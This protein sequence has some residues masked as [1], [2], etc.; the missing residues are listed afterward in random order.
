MKA[1][2]KILFL[3]SFAVIANALDTTEPFEIGFSN[4]EMYFITGGL[5]STGEKTFI[6]Y[7]YVTG[8]GITDR[9]ST[10]CAV[11]ATANENL[12]PLTH[13]VSTGVFY[14]AIT[15]SRVDIDF[16]A[17]FSTAGEYTLGTEIN[18]DLA[19]TG[20]QLMVE[21]AF[22]NATDDHTSIA[23]T[24]I[25][26][27]LIYRSLLEDIQLLAAFDIET[28]TDER[29]IDI[30]STHFG[31]NAIVTDVVE[32][33]TQLSLVMPTHAERVRTSISIGFVATIP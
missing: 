6:G 25:L 30:S 21:Q 5:G 11:S 31:C 8:I 26:T 29:D 17:R 24:T 19:K 4:N 33:I 2:L 7:E 16:S 27:P 3:F 32:L 23:A 20:F 13:A 9:F 10:L 28:P 18:Y 22:A 1:P 12:A 14:S 15:T